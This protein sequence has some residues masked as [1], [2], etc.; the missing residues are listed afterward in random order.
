M[1]PLL[2]TRAD[3]GRACA[4]RMS[5]IVATEAAQ[6]QRGLSPADVCE[7]AVVAHR[8]QK[9]GPCCPSAPQ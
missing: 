2:C 7:L 9:G 3:R 6:A 8:D 5:A 1:P 4:Q